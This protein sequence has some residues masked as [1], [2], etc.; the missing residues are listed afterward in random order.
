MEIEIGKT[1]TVSP[2]WKKSLCEIEMFKNEETGK[3]LNIETT[4]RSGSFNIFIENEDEKAE[5]ESC[6]YIEG[7]QEEP[8]IWDFESYENIEMIE[9]W[10]GCAEDW[11]FF[12]SGDT[13]WTEEE[14]EALEEQYHEDMDDD[15]NEMFGFYDWLTDK[16]YESYGCN[17]QIFNGVM[18]EEGQ[19]EMESIND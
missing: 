3:A 4:W 11:T 19:Y 10:D 6:M 2:H 16:G 7:E 17:Y 18:V 8:G 5:L 12:G 13:A 9:S 14:S 1:Y 15:D